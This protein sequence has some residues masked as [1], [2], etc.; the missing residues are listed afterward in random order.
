M[1]NVQY[2]VSLIPGR[3]PAEGV[4]F[5]VCKMH[6]TWALVM[7][8]GMVLSLGCIGPEEEVTPTAAPATGDG[9]T[10]IKSVFTETGVEKVVNFLINNEEG[11]VKQA[12]ENYECVESEKGDFT[13]VDVVE[14]A[15]FLINNEGT[16]IE[17]AGVKHTVTGKEELDVIISVMPC[18]GEEAFLELVE[19]VSACGTVKESELPDI[20]A[21]VP[22]N[23]IPEINKIS[24]VAG[25]RFEPGA[26][27]VWAEV[28]G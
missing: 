28:A 27:D 6:K 1:W 20:H 21:S 18:C 10:E 5:L 2:A 11:E 16:E 3:K 17:L 8:L 26:A 7:L 19:I 23:E 9:E 13:K 24:D 4:E 14:V 22:A 15:N 25:I 12:G